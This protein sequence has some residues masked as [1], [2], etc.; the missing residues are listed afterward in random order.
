ML[1]TRWFPAI[2]P[3]QPSCLLHV[4]GRG[5]LPPIQFGDPECGAEVLPAHRDRISSAREVQ[6]FQR[7]QQVREDELETIPH[8][9]VLTYVVVAVEALE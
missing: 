3:A 1:L 5:A 7:G 8:T 2:L 6:A 9:A 4:V